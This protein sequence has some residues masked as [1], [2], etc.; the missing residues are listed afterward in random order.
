M[1]I[2]WEAVGVIIVS[3]GLI[4]TWV[5]NGKSNAKTYGR[6][7]KKVEDLCDKVDGLEDKMDKVV[8]DTTTMKIHCAEVSSTYGQK[9]KNI[10]SEVFGHPKRRKDDD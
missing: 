2:S 8:T 3:V 4:A 10:E 9:I 5:R 1:A 6:F 7:E